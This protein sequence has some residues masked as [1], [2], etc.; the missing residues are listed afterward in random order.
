MFKFSFKILSPINSAT[1]LL[2]NRGTPISVIIPLFRVIIHELQREGELMNIKTAIVDGLKKRMG[3]VDAQGNVKRIQW[4]ENRNLVL[5]TILDPRFKIG[6]YFEA[7]RHCEYR[8]W[9]INEAERAEM[10]V[11]FIIK[12]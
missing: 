1:F 3:K 6:S 5:S 9:L 11:I 12:F 7:D 10:T 4:D 2:Q 8:S